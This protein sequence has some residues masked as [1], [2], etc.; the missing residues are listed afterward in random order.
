MPFVIVTPERDV[1]TIH[2]PARINTVSP[3][4]AVAT[5]GG[6]QR[7]TLHGLPLVPDP[8]QPA[9]VLASMRFPTVIVKACPLAT[10]PASEAA[11][12]IALLPAVS[13]PLVAS[14]S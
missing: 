9:T 7:S 13:V 2:S 14:V 12:H 8:V 6:R 4:E 10:T 3:A 5:A 11:T 1:S